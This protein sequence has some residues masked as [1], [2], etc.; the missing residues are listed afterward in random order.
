MTRLT[1][2]LLQSVFMVLSGTNEIVSKDGNLELKWRDA[3]NG[4]IASKYNKKISGDK[5]WVEDS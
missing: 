4:E 2:D 3:D 1:D 5:S